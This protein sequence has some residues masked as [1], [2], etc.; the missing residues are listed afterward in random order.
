MHFLLKKLEQNVLFAAVGVASFTNDVVL[1]ASAVAMSAASHL[2]SALLQVSGHMRYFIV[3]DFLKITHNLVL[4]QLENSVL[5]LKLFQ[6][7]E[8]YCMLIVR[9]MLFLVILK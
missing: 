3:L 2:Q 4:M 8:I 1:S 5:V 6:D 9:G 7:I